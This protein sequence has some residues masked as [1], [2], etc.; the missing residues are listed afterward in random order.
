MGNAYETTGP[1]SDLTLTESL[2]ALS[3]GTT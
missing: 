1:I 2:G 3:I